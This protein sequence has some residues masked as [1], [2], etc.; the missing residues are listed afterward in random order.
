M[1]TLS[2]L[3]HDEEHISGI[4]KSV[5]Q[6]YLFPNYPELGENLFK[7]LHH[8]ANVNT[9]HLSANSFKQQAEKFLS[10][11]NDQTVLENYVKMYSNMKGDGSIDP[12]GMKGLL[13]ISYKIAMDSSRAASCIY[14]GQIINAVIVSCVSKFNIY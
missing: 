12:E 2:H 11:M 9:S 4:T 8:A 10:V 5:F 3:T 13:Y 1:Q 7:Y 14:A 6:R